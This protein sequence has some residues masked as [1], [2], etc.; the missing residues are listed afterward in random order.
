MTKRTNKEM[1]SALLSIVAVAEISDVDRIEMTDFINGKIAQIE[2]KA[3][4]VTP[5]KAKAE[6]E[7]TAFAE[8]VYNSLVKIDRPV[9]I[10]VLIAETPELAGIT[11]QKVTP[12]LT[13]LVNDGKV[14]RLT[15][16][17]DKLYSIKA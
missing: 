8:L 2:K 13:K 3:T 17:K 5:S 4:T 10:S 9:K 7:K 16:K 15:V 14:E 6:A 11:T 12:V 1:Y